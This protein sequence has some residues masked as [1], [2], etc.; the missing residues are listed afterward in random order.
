[1]CKAVFGRRSWHGCGVY[2]G[3][4]RCKRSD[5]KPGK[6]E[7]VGYQDK[8]GEGGYIERN[9]VF[10]G[11]SEKSDVKDFRGG[12]IN[13][14][15][16]EINLDLSDAQLA[17]GTHVLEINNVFGGSVITVPADW[18]LEIKRHEVFGRFSDNRPRAGFEIEENKKLVLVVSSV[19]GGG[20]VRCK[21]V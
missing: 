19:F 18:Y 16:G 5:Y 14:V 2:V 12:E 9:Y 15:F 3:E 8:K 11:G 10:G 20:E 4:G 1:L 21:A 7:W 17:E 13:C 6:R